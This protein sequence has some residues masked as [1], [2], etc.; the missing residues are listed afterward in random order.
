MN[1]NQESRILIVAQNASPIIGIK[2]KKR[3]LKDDCSELDQEELGTPVK[4]I[5]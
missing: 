3:R 5:W 1:G 4:T 2:N